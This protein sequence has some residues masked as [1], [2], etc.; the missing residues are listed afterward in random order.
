[1]RRISL[2]LQDGN[3]VPFTKLL[4]VMQK[5]GNDAIVSLSSEILRRLHKTNGKIKTSLLMCMY[6]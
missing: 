5:H 3:T 2:S 6:I 4:D 1:M